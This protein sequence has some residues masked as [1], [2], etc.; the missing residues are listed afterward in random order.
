M[1]DIF[2]SYARTDQAKA[3][4][5]ADAFVRQGWSVWWDR[6][7]PPGKSFD[8]VIEK[9]L[10]SAKCVIVLWSQQSVSSVWVKTEAAEG[11]R[12]GIL[13]PILIEDAKVPLE[14]RRIQT[15]SLFDWRG[16]LPH[17][18]LDELLKAVANLLG[19]AGTKG[20]K[21]GQ[22]SQPLENFESSY[23]DQPPRR[24]S[25][26][27]ETGGL[28]RIFK[29]WIVRWSLWGPIV[30]AVTGFV[31]GIIDDGPRFFTLE[32]FSTWVG[33]G[34]LWGLLGGAGVGIIFGALI[35]YYQS[36]D[37]L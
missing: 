7:I 29:F 1:S 22:I 26:G 5:L 32:L 6:N 13:V 16:T 31:L 3:K 11:A 2:I 25:R 24:I 19:D 8:E 34:A 35:Y 27:S 30:G 28:K 17:S 12:R 33:G 9:A 21:P 20:V 14:F 15:A 36:S 23:R 4:L 18:E 37:R 10:D